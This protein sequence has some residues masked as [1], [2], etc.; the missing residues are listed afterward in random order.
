MENQKMP[1]SLREVQLWIKWIVTDPRGVQEAYANPF[2]LNLPI[3]EANSERYTAPPKTA[4]P[5]IA[6]TPP[7]DKL[8]RLDIYAEAY[9]VRILE[10]MK[11]D[12]PI[13][14]RLLGDHSFQKLIADYLKQHPSRLSNIGEIGRF[15]SRFV[16]TY[17]NLNAATFLEPVIAMEWLM[18][19]SF[20]ADDTGLLDPAKLVSLSE[21]DWENAEFKLAY[22]VHLI[23]S[24]WALDQF[25]QLKDESVAVESVDL[26]EKKSAQSFLLLRQNGVVL[27][28]K[29]SD[30]E[31]KLLKKLHSGV[32]LS[33][34]L[35][36][37]EE[38]SQ[39]MTWF[40]NWVLRGIIYDLNLKQKR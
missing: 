29:I 27:L 40:N 33:A 13:T 21:E 12:F 10:S 35:E 18:I 14:A 24:P 1:P 7:L 4:A 30:A 22:F 11:A 38:D 19:E 15:F 26:E 31:F 37:S 25:W 6:D 2:P 16:A 28:E 23:E 9:F 39:I 34:A 20:Y 17:E 32:N 8:A 3:N 5:W 36:D